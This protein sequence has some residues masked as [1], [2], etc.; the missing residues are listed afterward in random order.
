M[1]K[2]HL[3]FLDTGRKETTFASSPTVALN[4][5]FKY[6]VKL[7]KVAPG[8][9]VR[10]DV[11]LANAGKA[12]RVARYEW[13]IHWQYKDEE[14]YSKREEKYQLATELIPEGWELYKQ[15]KQFQRRAVA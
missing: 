7:P 14:Y 9:E 5:F 8:N 15:D 3:T 4:W 11:V 12:I 1:D 10:L 6:N 13:Q 2:Y